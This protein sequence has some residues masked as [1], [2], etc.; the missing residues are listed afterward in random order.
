MNG[1]I[2]N[3]DDYGQNVA[4]VGVGAFVPADE[5]GHESQMAME[6]AAQRNI[7]W[8]N[9]KAADE[10][11]E[12]ERRKKAIL[13]VQVD[14]SGIRPIDKNPVLEAQDV[15]NKYVTQAY[16]SDKDPFDPKNAEEYQKVSAMM[17]AQKVLINTS[18]GLQKQIADEGKQFQNDKGLNFH[19]SSETNLRTAATIPMSDY[20]S[21]KHPRVQL[22]S[23]LLD[24]AD[25]WD[26]NK[27]LND[28]TKNKKTE[29]E[30]N[31]GSNK[32][33]YEGTDSPAQ[34]DKDGNPIPGTSGREQ[35]AAAVISDP[36]A[37]KHFVDEMNNPVNAP[38]TRQA[39]LQSDK[40][41]QET[42]RYVK[43]E[44]IYASYRIK[45]WMTKAYKNSHEDADIAA[46]RK[47]AVHAA[48]KGLDQQKEEELGI[49]QYHRVQNSLAGRGET[50]QD[51]QGNTIA[52]DLT[53]EKVG[54]WLNAEG[55]QVPE[56]ITKVDV[57]N[58]DRIKVYTNLSEEAFKKKKTPDP[59]VEM[60]KS[61]FIQDYMSPILK[62]NGSKDVSSSWKGVEKAG[63]KEFEPGMGY[64]NKKYVE[65]TYGPQVLAPDAKVESSIEGANNSPSVIQR[66]AS[67]IKKASTYIPGNSKPATPAKATTQAEFDSQWKVAKPGDKVMGPDGIMYIKKKNK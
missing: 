53:G 52:A 29:W 7:D 20:L 40:I 36:K 26:V 48:N 63:K 9:Q 56:Y 33:R 8:Q 64:N 27:Y 57:S 37:Y 13:D 14:P 5:H 1:Q 55:R 45:P 51:E 25:K 38:L 3:W 35:F 67:L 17:N 31:Q 4:G 42:G 2:L 60:P 23:T 32:V 21:G 11:K 43:P 12:I 34:K 39:Y 22:G 54:I 61:K 47:V 15:I 66:A 24:P 19:P 16:A 59:F 41:L 30:E 65:N 10:Q 44:E 58:P 46:N 28:L 49:A 50:Y 18:S 6:K 62:N